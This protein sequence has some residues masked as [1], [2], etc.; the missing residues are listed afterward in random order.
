MRSHARIS[1][2]ALLTGALIALSLPA[3]AQAQPGIESFF[4]VN[5]NEAHEE[6]KKPANKSEEVEKAEAEGFTQA[7]GHPNWG[8][9]D[10]KI[11]TKG[12][13]PHE[14]PEG[15]VSHIRTD[16]APGL[17]TDPQA[18]KKCS[19]AEFGAKEAIAG[20]GFYAEP[21]CKAE[22]KLG[23]NKAVVFLGA[24]GDLPLEGNV[25]NL[26][27]PKGLASDFGVALKLPIPLTKEVL[28]KAFAE[29]GNP[30]KEPVE[31]KFL[32][33][34]Q[35]FA[36]TLIEGNVEWGAEA[37]GTGKADY[38]DYFEINVSTALP[39]ISSRL[40]FNGR[41][42][43]GDFLTNPTACYGPGPATTSQL[44]LEFEGGGTATETYTSPIGL[45]GCGLVPFNPGFAL[46]EE[47]TGS[48]RP[49][50]LSAELSIPHFPNPT[51][52]DSSQVNTASVT[53]PP[54]ITL[55]PSG[56]N[57]LEACTAAEVGIGTKKP[58]EC[59]EGSKIGTVS[60][61]VPGL[62][63]GSLTGTIYLGAESLPITGPPY[64]IWVTA[65]SK[66]YN[67]IVR[68]KGRTTPNPATGQ[69][70]TTF[71]ENPEQPFSN[72]VLHF[73]GG[74]LASLANGLKCEASAA[75]ATLTPF[76]NT[77]AMSPTANFEVNGCPA[78][79]PFSLGQSTQNQ[80]STGG[81]H[82]SYTF[83]LARA[84]GQQY[85][86]RIKTTLPEGLVGT[87]PSI[88]LCNEPQAAAGTCGAASQIGTAT[89]TAGA[90]R[91]PYTFSGPV[92]MTGPYNGAPYGLSI[93]VPA[94]A[95]PF[96]LGLVVTRSTININ[97]STSRVTAESV[98]PTIVAGIPMRL[99]SISVNVNRQ[100][101]LLNPTNCSAE[102]TETTLTSTF[103]AVQE[104]LSSPFQLEACNAL[105]FKPSF[106]AATT[107]KT[108]KANGASIETTLSQGAGQANIKSVLVQLPKQ[109]PS[110]LTTLQKACPE[111]T[112]AANPSSCPEGSVVGS[113]RASTPV[114]PNKLTGPAYFVSHGSEAFPD[115]DL[116]LE[117]DGVRTILVGNTNI[118]KGITTTNFASTPDVPVTSI[119]VTLPTGPHSALAANGNLCVPTLVMP[120]TITGQNGA[121][122]K[123]NTKITPTGC[124]V[125]IV[126]HKV[127]GGTAYLTIKTFAAGRLSGSGSGL[128]KV[129]RSLAN[130]SN[131]V[132]L[133]VPLSRGG[134]SRRRPFSV[135][136]RVGFVPKKGAHSTAY[137]TVRFR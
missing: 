136:V 75:T 121:K 124:G 6:C 4:A 57:G 94:V 103:G 67:V 74:P 52:I 89:V 83:N 84:D 12:T 134:R 99:K 11:N 64:I 17:A 54:G 92:Y 13:F 72:L 65:E 44:K 9:T 97:P 122:V 56:A 91:I 117:A 95:G 80:T 40:V 19:L 109:L 25:Y 132:S 73:N 24:E 62:P 46:E 106:K 15:V 22:T 128:S 102:A 48:D 14:E 120:T 27:Q 100:G 39:L 78:A 108:S 90:G 76:T 104:G 26:S 58:I 130:A 16:V 33:E 127:I 126:G 38:H 113:A 3:A 49:D 10:F 111:A 70:T 7:A 18:V 66:Y 131:A 43:E 71:T 8:I 93:A 129:S 115:L 88:T 59:P 29:L 28:E 1:L 20:T 42:G 137:I 86:E 32:T 118:K 34:Q 116:V 110:R 36:H 63:N 96:N 68:V 123:L 21:E 23:V 101:F 114:L 105:A 31:E 60:L 5:C 45:T 107:S 77:A 35:Y 87:I 2:S 82:T 85:L 112:F 51:E 30:L 119:T 133:K 69:L 53:L 37:N 47:T 61:N 41:A 98:L 125:Q 55:N 81:G 50:G 135:R 79:L